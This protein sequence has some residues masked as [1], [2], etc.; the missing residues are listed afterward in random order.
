[1]HVISVASYVIINA[2]ATQKKY[3]EMF[4]NGLIVLTSKGQSSGIGFLV[5]SLACDN[6]QRPV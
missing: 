6:C 1:M 5:A 3:S 4:F 2:S